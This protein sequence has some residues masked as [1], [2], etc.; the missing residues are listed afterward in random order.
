MNIFLIQTPDPST[1]TGG[2]TPENAEQQQTSGALTATTTAMVRITG[3]TFVS[4]TATNSTTI[5]EPN[6]FTL[7]RKN[8]NNQ[9]RVTPGGTSLPAGTAF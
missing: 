9:V 5:I 2:V 8:G 3:T 7:V 4:T 6:K 1:D